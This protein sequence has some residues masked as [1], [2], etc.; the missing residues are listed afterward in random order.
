M[1]K[2]NCSKVDF[3]ALNKEC[4]KRT[5]QKLRKKLETAKLKTLPLQKAPIFS[6]IYKLRKTLMQ[7]DLPN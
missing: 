6:R 5:N 7:I 4:S 2:K 1:K 3:L